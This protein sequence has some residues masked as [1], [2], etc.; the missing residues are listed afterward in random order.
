MVAPRE[1]AWPYEDHAAQHHVGQLRQLIQAEA[2][3]EVAY[4]RHA[5]I[6]LNL[7]QPFA[8]LVELLHLRDQLIGTLVHRAELVHPKRF[9]VYA[10]TILHK[11]DRPPAGQAYRQGNQ[12][13]Q[14]RHGRQRQDACQQRQDAAD[15]ALL[16]VGTGGVEVHQ[17]Y[18]VYPVGWH[19]R[20]PH[21]DVQLLGQDF[22]RQVQFVGQLQYQHDLR[23][24]K[25]L[26]CANN[27]VGTLLPGRP[28]QGIHKGGR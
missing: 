10:H 14:R 7:K 22:D 23:D 16:P 1:R 24:L 20:L 25:L 12:P 18:A 4:T 19:T 9:T 6:I 3:Q 15:L 8:R 21:H 11:E 26:L 5:W 28:L 13:Q 2:A 17:W 27:Q